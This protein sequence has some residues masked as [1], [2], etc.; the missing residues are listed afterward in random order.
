MASLAT[1]AQLCI[2]RTLPHTYAT[3]VIHTALWRKS[4]CLGRADGGEDMGGNHH[5]WQVR[6]NGLP[7]RTSEEGTGLGG[8]GG[9]GAGHDDDD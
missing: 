5:F 3:Y 4:S 9:G 6:Q 1:V 7:L 8:R 2:G